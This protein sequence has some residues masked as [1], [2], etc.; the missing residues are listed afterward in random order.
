M[1]IRWTWDW[2]IFYSRL[3]EPEQILRLL[4]WIWLHKYACIY[5]LATPPRRIRWPVTSKGRGAPRRRPTH[6][7]RRKSCLRWGLTWQKRR[8]TLQPG[9]AANAEVWLL[10]SH[11]CIREDAILET[12]QGFDSTG[13]LSPRGSERPTAVDSKNLGRGF[14]PR[15]REGAGGAF[16][17]AAN[18]CLLLWMQK[19]R[20]AHLYTLNNREESWGR[21]KKSLQSS[22]LGRREGNSFA[23]KTFSDS[24]ISS[25]LADH[26]EN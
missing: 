6:P 19:R 4:V 23:F 25:S 8:L 5:V 12:I 3:I 18:P 11:I 15:V 10:T 7:P 22:R 24:F 2:I 21:K 26:K 17:T 9:T 1:C 13:T 20:E 14:G 16:C